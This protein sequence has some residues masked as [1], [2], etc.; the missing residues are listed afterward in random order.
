[1]KRMHKTSLAFV[2]LLTWVCSACSLLAARPAGLSDAQI[3]D[4]AEKILT[5]LNQSDYAQFKQPMS[6][7]MVKAMPES[8]FLKLSAMLSQTSGLYLSKGQPELTNNQGAAI[9]RFTCKFEKEDVIVT[10]VYTISGTQV[11]GLFFD[12]PGLRATAQPK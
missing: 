6:D 3:G 9:Y 5:A 8:A 11:E 10:L 2:A 7:T 1:M 12:S 4:A